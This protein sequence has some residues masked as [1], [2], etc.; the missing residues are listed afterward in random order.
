MDFLKIVAELGFPMA[1]A[2]AAGYFSANLSVAAGSAATY[3]YNSADVKWY[4]I[5]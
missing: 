4:K 2:F 3:F 1:S 5:G